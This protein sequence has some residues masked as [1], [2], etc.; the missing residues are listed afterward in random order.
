MLVLPEGI[1]H[2]FTL[3]ENDYITAMRLFVGAPVWTPFNRPQEEHP[4]RTKYL[5]DFA[6]DAA[7]PA[8]AAA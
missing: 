5:R 6:G 8:V 7:A 2:R 3:D 1:Y 4:S